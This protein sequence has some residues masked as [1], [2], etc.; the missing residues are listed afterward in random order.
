MTRVLFVV[1]VYQ[2]Q[3]Y[4]YAKQGFAD[5]ADRVEVVMDRRVGDRRGREAR[6]ARDQRQTDR[7]RRDIAEHLRS[8]GWA[9]VPLPV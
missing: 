5:V 7:R 1:S 8:H 6:T 2:P 4:T 9:L 3:L